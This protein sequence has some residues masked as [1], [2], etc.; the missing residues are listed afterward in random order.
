MRGLKRFCILALGLGVAGCGDDELPDYFLLDRMRVIAAHTGGAAA[1]FSAGDS[2]SVVFHLVDPKGGGRTLTY[3][4]EACVDPGVGIGAT[5]NCEGNPTMQ[6]I[7]SGATVVPGSAATNYYGT[8][9]TPAISIPSAAVV[10]V[11]PR[12]GSARPLSDQENGVGYLIVLRMVASPTETVTAFKRL[13]VSTKATKNQNPTWSA[14]ALLFDGVAPASYVLTTDRFPMRAQVAPTSVESYNRR[15][16]DGSSENR[17]EELLITWLVST[18]EIR[19]SRTEPATENRYT[20][21]APLPAW[22]SFIAVVR[23]ERGG[24]AVVDFHK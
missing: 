14:P 13:V 6:T 15:L 17:S 21:A 5:P 24:M 3:S 11:D 12:T 16:A 2:A 10:F 9:T 1:E 23:D 4:I 18:G 22:T 20:P 8:L 19:F 7:V